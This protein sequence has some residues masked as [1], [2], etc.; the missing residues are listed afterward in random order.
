LNDL[1]ALDP[2]PEPNGSNIRAVIRLFVA[3]VV[4]LVLPML[5]IAAM[6]HPEGC[7]GG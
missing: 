4:L 3:F 2:A 1:D 5:L 7:G 6:T